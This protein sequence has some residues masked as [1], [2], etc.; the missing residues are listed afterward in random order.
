M[1]APKKNLFALGLENSGR[2]PI[3]KDH[4]EMAKKIAEYIDYEDSRKRP[5]TFSGEGKGIYTIEGCA[6]FLGFASVTSFYDYEKRNEEFMYTLQ[7]Y[8]LFLTKWNAE[9]LYWGGTFAGAMFWLKNY[10]G[11]KDEV[12]QNQNQSITKVEIIEKK[13]DE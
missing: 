4:H 1:A 2:P 12:T 10:G 13:R 8:R 11:Y 3:Y 9:K 7:A 5:D 6:L